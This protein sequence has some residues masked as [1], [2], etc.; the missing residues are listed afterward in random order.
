MTASLYLVVPGPLSTR[1]GGYIYDRRMVE[2]LR[3]LGQK[4]E[5]VELSGAYPFPSAQD[6]ARAH[7]VFASIPDKSLVVVDGLALGALPD[8]AERHAQRLDLTALVHHPLADET[9]LADN[10]RAGLMLSEMRAL[11]VVRHV[12]VTSTFTRRRLATFGVPPERISVCVPGVDS[13]AIARGSFSDTL[14]L[15]CPASLT[16]RKGHADLFAAL[17]DL[18]ELNWRLICVGNPTLDPAHA[19]ALTNMIARLDLETRIDMR[20]E[21]SET[22]MH[23]LY[24]EADLFVLASLYEGFGM[25]VSEAVARGLPLVTTS[26]GALSETVPPAAAFVVPPG[27]VAALRE[28]LRLTISDSELRAKLAEGSR[29]ARG[30]LPDWKQAA[31]SFAHALMVARS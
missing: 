12:I 21:A 31:D 26:G 15:L 29:A 27:D 25:V 2:G 7:Q 1:T 30:H 10:E 16:P 3:A 13:A 4:V 22:E 17:A 24:D 28:A 20:S 14:V 6:V 8:I 9:G 19:A 11:A 5:V 18:R 23:A